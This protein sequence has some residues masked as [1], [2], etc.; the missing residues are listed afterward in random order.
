M[1]Q[2]LPAPEYLTARL[3]HARWIGG[4]SGA[5]TSTIVR[6]R[7]ADERQ[8]LHNSDAVIPNH[9]WRSDSVDTPLLQIFVAMDM[10]ERWANRSPEVMVRTFHWFAGEGLDLIVLIVDDR[11]GGR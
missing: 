9:A 11:T 2:M 8:R 5:A 3:R 1:R 7:A 10:D 6:R 4:G